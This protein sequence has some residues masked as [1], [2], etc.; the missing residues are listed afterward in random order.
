MHSDSAEDEAM[1]ALA[2]ITGLV[3]IARLPALWS[4]RAAMRTRL[5]A[6]PERLLADL[7]LDREAV[8]REA[9]R[10]FWRPFGACLAVDLSP[11][12]PAAVP[13]PAA[14]MPAALRELAR[15]PGATFPL[16]S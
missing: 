15:L 12:G 3:R 9:H 4:E 7:G 5:E 16:L 2:V 14:P 11:L 13:G 1:K 8:L 10:P 6:L